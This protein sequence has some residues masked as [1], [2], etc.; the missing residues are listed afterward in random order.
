LSSST[1]FVRMVQQR[2]KKELR[3]QQI[4]GKISV[5]KDTS[6]QSRVAAD[7]VN[8]LH[9][10]QPGRTTVLHPTTAELQAEYVLNRLLLNKKEKDRKT[11]LSK[12][13]EKEIR[14]YAELR[15][16]AGKLDTKKSD[17]RELIEEFDALSPGV[18]FAI[19]KTK[20]YLPK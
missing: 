8:E 12:V 2:V 9:R 20:K 3:E 18:V 5:A 13:T 1:Q 16:I 14:R 7:I 10:E 19:N 11:I 17:V 15:D 6:L 4:K